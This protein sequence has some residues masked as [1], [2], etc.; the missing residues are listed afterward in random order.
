[1]TSVPGGNHD[2]PFTSRKS[3]SKSY[4]LLSRQKALNGQPDSCLKK[5]KCL[6]NE[7]ETD[8]LQ[9]IVHEKLLIRRG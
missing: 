3:T 4:K 9:K 5:K 8:S 2:A 6:F 1:M 7:A